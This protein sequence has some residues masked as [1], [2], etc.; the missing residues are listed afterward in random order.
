[1]RSVVEGRRQEEA[2][3]RDKYDVV[4]IGGGPA[5]LSA[6]TVLG[7]S[8]RSVLVVDAGEPRNARAAHAHNVFTR[9]GVAPLDLLAAGRDE[10]TRYGGEIEVATASDVRRDDDGFVVVLADGRTVAARRILSAAGLR[11]VL[12]DVPGLAELWGTD[13]LHCPY[14][15]G[16]E[17]RDQPLGILG[18]GTL[19][20]HTA[21]LF[22]QLTDDVTVFVHT[23]DEPPAD[24]L[25]RLA[26]RG[27]RI[28]RGEVVGVETNGGRLR[29]VRLSSGEVV[30][31]RALAVRPQFLARAEH[32]A[33]LGLHAQPVEVQGQVMGAAVPSDAMGATSVPGVW[34]A[35][36]VTDLGGQV[37]T[38]A[39]AG[40]MAGAAINADLVARDTDQAVAAAGEHEHDEREHH[41]H[42]AAD[43]DGMFDVAFWE[44]RYSGKEPA[45]SGRANATLVAEV[46]GL[47]PGTALE[48]AAGEGGDAMWLAEQGWQVT[49]TDFAAAGLARGAAEAAERGIADRIT[50]R[51]A[52][53]TAWADD[54]TYDLVTA[55]YLHPAPE[56]RAAVTRTMASLVAPGGHLLIVGHHVLDLA[57]TMPRPNI[58]ELFTDADELLTHL[59]PAQWDVLACEARPR[60]A[61]DPE[62]RPVRL[63]EAV[64]HLRR[65]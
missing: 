15:H 53:I 45:W 46:S 2:D 54:A 3:V 49:A 31:V 44:E 7:R 26:A 36:N 33:G 16:W 18:G 51:Q 50:W 61:A 43:L 58:P 57:T 13:V 6:A 37:M 60:D 22:R 19:S 21:H 5:G 52:D 40:L 39:A 14:C 32:L 24:A 47:A 11:D 25:A 48:I 64:L 62:G 10:V 20:L 38:S 17:V 28:V 9:D 42:G 8:R 4:V 56:R 30:A 34:V 27:M 1:V 23:D 65:R 29:G 35:G 63:H 12:P 59:D 41:G 55:H